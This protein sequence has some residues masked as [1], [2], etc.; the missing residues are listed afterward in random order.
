MNNTRMPLHNMTTQLTNNATGWIG[1]VPGNNEHLVKGQTFIAGE[2]ADL[3]AVKIFPN[4]VAGENNVSVTLYDFDPANEQWGQPI[5][6][7]SR[8]L[9]KEDAGQWISFDLSGS[10]LEKGKAYGFR[11]DTQPSYIG[12]AEACSSSR[13]PV[14]NSGKEWLFTDSNP[15]G[16]AYSYLSLVFKIEVI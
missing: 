7:A 2:E 5:H 1:D 16:D 8:E 9:K 10:H 6:A 4:M 14:F 3:V 15:A 12:I 13:Q 11:L